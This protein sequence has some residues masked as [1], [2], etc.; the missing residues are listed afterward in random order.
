[1]RWERLR[2]F[3]CLTLAVV[4]RSIPACPSL[5]SRKQANSHHSTVEYAL[6]VSN[7]LPALVL[8]AA[9]AAPQP[10]ST[11]GCAEAARTLHAAQRSG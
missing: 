9:I 10:E 11:A 6:I 4:R 1:M 5:C 3:L 8:Q 2:V 7:P